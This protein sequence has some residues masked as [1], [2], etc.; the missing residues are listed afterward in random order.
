M[1]ILVA[2]RLGLGIPWTM[3]IFTIHMMNKRTW[4][5]ARAMRSE[6]NTRRKLSEFGYTFPMKE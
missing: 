2:N 1:K 3:K 5:G 4:S 6:K